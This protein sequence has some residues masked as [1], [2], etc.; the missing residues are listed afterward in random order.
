M[1]R[2]IGRGEVLVSLREEVRG[3]VRELL[4]EGVEWYVTRVGDAFYILNEWVG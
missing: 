1:Q 4:A 3:A 2:G